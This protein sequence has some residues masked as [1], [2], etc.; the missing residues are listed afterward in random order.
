[1]N[2]LVHSGRTKISHGGFTYTMET[3]SHYQSVPSDLQPIVK[4]LAARYCS[5]LT[6]GQ[7]L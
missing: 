6:P 1:M 7:P 2:P 4:Y 3:G 5:H